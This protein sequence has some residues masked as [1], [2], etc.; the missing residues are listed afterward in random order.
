M[1][2]TM[3]DLIGQRVKLSRSTITV[4]DKDGKTRGM[5]RGLTCWDD[6]PFNQ[7]VQVK[8]EITPLWGNKLGL[9]M[10]RLYLLGKQPYYIFVEVPSEYLIPGFNAEQ[11]QEELEIMNQLEQNGVTVIKVRSV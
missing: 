5:V 9:L 7:Q 3:H 11:Y 4:K 10:N 1:A 2:T 8:K 6:L